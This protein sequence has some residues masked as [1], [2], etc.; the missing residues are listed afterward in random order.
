MVRIQDTV[1]LKQ[2]EFIGQTVE[3]AETFF[4]GTITRPDA[5]KERFPIHPIATF[6]GEGDDPDAVLVKLVQENFLAV[7]RQVRETLALH[8]NT[9]AEAREARNADS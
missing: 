9:L 1:K 2:G 8:V 4:Q 7:R 3:T 6:G 5:T